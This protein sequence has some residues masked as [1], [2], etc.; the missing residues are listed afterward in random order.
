MNRRI[1]KN[2][3]VCNFYL[4]HSCVDICSRFRSYIWRACHLRLYKLRSLLKGLVV[5][6][7]VLPI[8]V[9]M[10]TL[11]TRYRNKA[12]YSDFLVSFF[13][14]VRKI[15]F[16]NHQP[17]LIA[18]SLVLRLSDSVTYRRQHNELHTEIFIS[19]CPYHSQ[20]Q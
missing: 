10:V 14:S 6:K 3:N 12:Y 1:S 7:T 8:F 15:T 16:P 4:L 18:H 17:M 2:A 9:H 5:S 20:M 11:F 19:A 13:L